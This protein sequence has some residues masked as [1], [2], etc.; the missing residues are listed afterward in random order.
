MGYHESFVVDKI[1]RTNNDDVSI[2][3]K[4]LGLTNSTLTDITKNNAVISAKH[5]CRKGETT[6]LFLYL[7]DVYFRL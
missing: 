4:G 3:Y 2:S 5:R 1:S 7:K 6:A